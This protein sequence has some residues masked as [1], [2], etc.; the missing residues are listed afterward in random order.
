MPINY[1]F[2]KCPTCAFAWKKREDFLNDKNLKI[3]GY[4]ANFKSLP[5]GL[6]L[7]NHTCGTTLAVSAE[8]FVDLYDG[9]VY[10]E[11]KTGTDECPGYCLHKD[12]LR[13]CPA[14]C[15]CAWVRELLQI[16]KK[17]KE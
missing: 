11:R 4:Q 12:E 8:G 1:T 3:V 17:M 6:F 2:K 10:E 14:K 7:F 5:L 13:R 9:P 15:E 16:I